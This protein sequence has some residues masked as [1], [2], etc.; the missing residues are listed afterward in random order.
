MTERIIRAQPRPEDEDIVGRP[1]SPERLA[2]LYPD[3]ENLAFWDFVQQL[4][5]NNRSKFCVSRAMLDYDPEIR[6]FEIGK[7][8]RREAPEIIYLGCGKAPDITETKSQFAATTW[9][10][11]VLKLGGEVNG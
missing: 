11:A 2:E 3:R 8:K 10:F 5:S 7:V 1:I 6:F 9:G 4:R